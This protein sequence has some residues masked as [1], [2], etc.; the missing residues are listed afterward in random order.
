M[1]VPA[2]KIKF[3][4]RKLIEQAVSFADLDKRV[5]EYE[6]A[7]ET[8]YDNGHLSQREKVKMLEECLEWQNT[9]SANVLYL[10][11]AFYD[12]GEHQI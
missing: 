11:N 8:A 2:Y 10:N 1:N 7:L 9:G 3:K 5:Q 12:V 6:D 4:Y